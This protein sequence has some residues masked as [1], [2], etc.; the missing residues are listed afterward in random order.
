MHWPGNKDRRDLNWQ[1]KGG[2]ASY[3]KINTALNTHTQDHYPGYRDK[4]S[5]GCEQ[6]LYSNHKQ[7]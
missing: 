1:R 5:S 3:L 4:N 2:I 7:T 6:I